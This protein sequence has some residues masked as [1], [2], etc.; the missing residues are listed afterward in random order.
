MV[1]YREYT[2]KVTEK[3][4]NLILKGLVHLIDPKKGVPRGD[5]RKDIAELNHR[6][7]QNVVNMLK[8]QAEQ[9]ARKVA[10]GLEILDNVNESEPKSHELPE[11]TELNLSKILKEYMK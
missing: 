8:L 4:L 3:E 10:Y 11:G 7:L 6:L 5:E 2:I 1:Q 9:Y